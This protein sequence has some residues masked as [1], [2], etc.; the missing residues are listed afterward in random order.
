MLGSDFLSVPEVKRGPLIFDIPDNE[1]ADD[2]SLVEGPM[3]ESAQDSKD[4][5]VTER[6][7]RVKLS[8]KTFFSYSLLVGTRSTDGL[9]SVPMNYPSRHVL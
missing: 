1:D 8:H 4:E 6:A 5:V 3:T 7:D 2:I 9:L